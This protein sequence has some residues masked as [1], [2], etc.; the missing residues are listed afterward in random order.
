MLENITPVRDQISLVC[1][2]K[3]HHILALWDDNM[4]D[5][6]AVLKWFYD[7]CVKAGPQDCPIYEPTSQKISERVT[8]LFEQLKSQ[9]VSFYNAST[10]AHGTVN[11]STAKG[12][13]FMMLYNPGR[14]GKGIAQALAALE[15][16]DAEPM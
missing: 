5:T 12:R 8:R 13:M 4:L 15:S 11:Y 6:D 7:D 16:G 9:P 14:D 1:A 3:T 10:G 2:L